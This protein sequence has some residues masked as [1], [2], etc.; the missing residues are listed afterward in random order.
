MMPKDDANTLSILRSNIDEID[1][2]IVAL[3][4][5]RNTQVKEVVALK[6]KHRLPALHPA[7]EENL[8]SERRNQALADGL[9]PDYVE[10]LFR[11]ILRESRR[12]QT[13]HISRRGIRPGATV[14]LVG[15]QG[16]M[17]CYFRKWFSNAG[18]HVRGMDQDDWNDI[19]N[20]CDGID[21]AIISVPINT[22]VPVIKRIAPHLPPD[23]VLADLTSIKTAPLTAMLAA[24]SGPVIGLH[25]LFG[26]TTSTMDKQI[27]AVTPG[28]RSSD[29]QW[30]MDQFASWG[31]VL[32]ETNAEE[33]DEIM[34]IVQSLRHF[35]TFSFGR[36]LHSKQAN[37]QRSLE[38]SSPIYRLELGM[39]GRLFAQAPELYAE[40]IFASSQR[41]GLL[42]EYISDLSESLEMIEKGDKAAFKTQFRKIAEWFGPFSEQAMRESSYL[43]DKL[44]ER[45]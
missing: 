36:F 25:P 3:L 22:T 21:L 44:I 28:R 43:I 8:I 45:F 27:V 26:P 39:V 15:V 30:V 5:Q 9:N 18:Y 19:K 7:R 11:C 4:T 34:A 29:C 42:K 31:T 12:E 33:H 10:E 20:L 24:H 35:A 2:Q 32:V 1:R 13:V 16:S 17:G 6:K 41:L 38:F 37:L 40:I 23:C 14:L